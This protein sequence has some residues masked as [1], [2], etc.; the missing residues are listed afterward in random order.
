MTSYSMAEGEWVV[1]ADAGWD[2][3]LASGTP[4]ADAGAAVSE[5]AVEPVVEAAEPAGL[6][7]PAASVVATEVT[8]AAADQDWADW[9]AATGNDWQDSANDYLDYALQ[10]AEAGNTAIAASALD[11]AATHAGIAQDHYGTS[12][13]YEIDVADHVATAAAEAV[14]YDTD[15]GSG[16][17]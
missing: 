6:P 8:G 17:V 11:T 13:D 7:E 10:N 2:D 9:H 1:S 4:A 12:S 3:Y 14:V 15:P 5:P 16:V